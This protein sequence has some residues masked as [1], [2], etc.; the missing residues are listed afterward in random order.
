MNSYT[1]QTVGTYRLDQLIHRG[2]ISTV[3]R[4]T[5]LRNHQT[6]AV[7]VL[8]TNV[9]ADPQLLARFQ[10]EAQVQ[11]RLIHRSIVTVLDYI[12]QS[13]FIAIVM[14]YVDGKNLDELLY[15][16]SGPMP[17]SEIRNLMIPLLDAMGYAHDMGIIHRDLKPSNIL[18][19][20]IDGEWVPKIMDFGIAK[21]IAERELTKTNPGV[22]LGTLLY[23]SPEQC[24]ALKTIDARSDIYSL[25]ITLYQM[26]TGMVPFYAESAFEIMLAH[27]QLAPTLPSQLCAEISPELE[28]VILKALEK[29]PDQRFQTI[30]EMANAIVALRDRPT[31][32]RNGRIAH[33]SPSDLVAMP[34]QV[35]S[36]PTFVP[37]SGKSLDISTGAITPA[38]PKRR[39]P[40]LTAQEDSIRLLDPLG[41]LTHSADR[42][43]HRPAQPATPS[44]PTSEP[45]RETGSA[46]EEF[47]RSQP[48]ISVE[49]RLRLRIPQKG[50]WP[51]YFQNNAAGG[52]V[53]CPTSQ[54]PDV[55]T[56]VRLEITFVG[57][58]R[59]TMLGVVTWRRATLNDPRARP[60]V[61]IQFH[62]HEHSKVNYI[63]AWVSGSVKDNRHQRRLPVR[64]RASYSAH[65][66][67]RVNFTRDI[68]EAGVF[69]RSQELLAVGTPI[70]LTLM[71][72]TKQIPYPLHGAVS[73]VVEEKD[74]RG[75]GIRLLFSDEIDSSRFKLFIEELEEKLLRGEL[76]DDVIS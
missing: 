29:D 66:G 30:G 61:G 10:A 40:E 27:V 48:S 37:E 72:P 41:G 2:L 35:F 21:V 42:S 22:M 39:A 76:P 73:R 68:S 52:G 57:G 47:A 24:K 11:S 7:K 69:I 59:F 19:T 28:A 31:L 70:E 25:G 12:S 55:G 14:E 34:K 63:N 38:S 53:F 13:N 32:I 71:H 3:Y 58:P 33:A 64:L 20:H 26:A 44:E 49:N 16:R 4:A 9:S 51:R 67:R 75:M 1:G 56:Q 54:P 15:E 18:V 17:L 6:V 36:A 8:T 50:D 46:E 5:N 60:G 45:M 65:T 23:M 43:L 62:P 74:L